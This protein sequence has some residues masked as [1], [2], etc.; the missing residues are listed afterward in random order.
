MEPHDLERLLNNARQE[1]VRRRNYYTTTEHL[2][3]VLL[4]EREII[5][6]F[7]YFNIPI[8]FVNAQL[9]RFFKQA[10]EQADR[11]EPL[12]KLWEPT[13]GLNDTISQV[14]VH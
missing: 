4:Q 11:K 9:E 6:A 12:E 2:F 5:D 10:L 8:K 7:A 14:V 3:L 13:D 1:A